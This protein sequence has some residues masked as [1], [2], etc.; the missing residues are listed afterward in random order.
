[1]AFIY[2]ALGGRTH[3]VP[4]AYGYVPLK[5]STQLPLPLVMEHGMPKS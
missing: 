1:M 4:L 2:P 5:T 3:G